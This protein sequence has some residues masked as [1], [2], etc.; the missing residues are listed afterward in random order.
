MKPSKHIM[1]ASST[2]ANV[3]QLMY[4]KGLLKSP[5]SHRLKERRD[6]KLAC[7]K[8]EPMVLRS[9][10]AGES[11]LRYALPIPSSKTQD[12]LG[13]D[14]KIKMI[15]KR[16][17]MLVSSL[18]ETFGLNTQ[19][20]EEETAIGPQ[21]EEVEENM[22]SFLMC[23]SHL[24][25][26][27]ESAVK[28]E[29]TIL[30][31][32]SK[33]F[34]GQVSQ[35]Y[36]ELEQGQE[37]LS[38]DPALLELAAAN[39]PVTPSTAHILQNEDEPR[40][41]SWQ[42]SVPIMN[43]ENSPVVVKSYETVKHQIEDA[44]YSMTT[45]LDMMLEIFE[46]HSNMWKR[47]M[48]ERGVLEAKYKQIQSDL[49]SLSQEKRALENKL[50]R[51]KDPEKA[52]IYDDSTKKI[53]KPEKKKDKGKMEEAEWKMGATKQLK[54]KEDFQ[55]VQKLAGNL[56]SENRI[57]WEKLKVALEEAERA[58]HQLD[59]FLNQQKTK[60]ILERGKIKMKGED[61]VEKRGGKLML[62]RRSSDDIHRYPEITAGEFRRSIGES[63][64]KERADSTLSNLSQ[65][66]GSEGY[67]LWEM[68]LE[69]AAA[70]RAAHLSSR[71]SRDSQGLLATEALPPGSTRVKLS[72]TEPT[73]PGTG[74][75]QVDVS[76]E[77]LRKKD[78]KDSQGE[79]VLDKQSSASESQGRKVKQRIV[80][81]DRRKAFLINPTSPE[82][83]I[84]MARR[85]SETESIYETIGEEPDENTVS[86]QSEYQ[87]AKREG[88]VK[89]KRISKGET[90][91][92]HYEELNENTIGRHQESMS[93]SRLQE[94]K[95]SVSSG[96][97]VTTQSKKTEE[98]LKHQPEDSVAKTQKGVKKQRKSKEGKPSYSKEEPYE[99]LVVQ[100][101]HSTSKSEIEA[102]TQRASTGEVFT[103]PY[104]V[105]GE[106]LVEHQDADS[107]LEIHTEE[108][109]VF[110][111]ERAIPLETQEKEISLEA[112]VPE[113]HAVLP[114]R[115]SQVKTPEPVKK[116]SLKVQTVEE[117]SDDYIKPEDKF[118]VLKSPPQVT[119]TESLKI[120]NILSS[121]RVVQEADQHV[122]PS[123]SKP[124][125]HTQ[126]S[127]ARNAQLK[128]PDH[129][130]TKLP[131]ESFILK[132]VETGHKVQIKTSDS[133]Q[134]R[135]LTTKHETMPEPP[136]KVKS[137][138]VSGTSI[139]DLI[140]HLGLDKVIEF[141]QL[142]IAMFT[143]LCS[144]KIG[145]VTSDFI[146]FAET[147]FMACY[148]VYL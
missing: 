47:T 119:K 130:L 62:G 26:Q 21:Q 6:R 109:N 95:D 53:V 85:E 138:P 20:G 52:K 88:K 50:R 137:V 83:M 66:L 87:D 49:E 55:N 67:S 84:L 77:E 106:N 32:L 101:Q 4:Q 13:K 10:P 72:F 19:E 74:D 147:C 79:N 111:D 104:K 128:T 56:E 7:D 5:L 44:A 134:P 121:Q 1:S 8:A 41:H 30:G 110:T 82:D 115:E 120:D 122:L 12:L 112:V 92:T 24:A 142:L 29:H 42:E 81:G 63:S 28:Q 3:P 96:E 22:K 145:D 36:E 68:P 59:N 102:K 39:Q 135:I 51:L 103:T 78:K 143:E 139:D 97:R 86:E 48:K 118:A 125:D 65:Y 23:C 64:E 73:A 116:E 17:G 107:Q 34:H 38:Q 126:M 127:E 58:K 70:K 114:R 146:E 94:Q 108:Q 61:S 33:W 89:K 43:S 144:E 123:E 54:M 117:K 129:D 2:W 105:S 113:E 16:L 91:S 98:N 136:N 40:R 71:G 46:K 9:P 69:I 140:L 27:L 60:A 90:L 57:L 75:A 131:E 18:E 132:G 37:I 76:E 25:A 45:K 124:K 133:K 93:K 31:S 100:P 80:K 141:V 148:I 11:L 99:N 35:L 15:T 14:E